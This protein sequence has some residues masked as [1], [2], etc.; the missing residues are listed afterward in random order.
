VHYITTA[1]PWL[2][3]QALVHSCHFISREEQSL[4]VT[5]FKSDLLSSTCPSQAVALWT[6]TFVV[7]A[8]CLELLVCLTKSMSNYKIQFSFLFNERSR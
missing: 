5:H 6:K 3:S 8:I 1:V 2:G 4:V 7:G